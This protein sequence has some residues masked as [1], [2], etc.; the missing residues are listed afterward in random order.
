MT[1]MDE[2]LHLR[3][4]PRAT[5]V[6][7]HDF[8]AYFDAN[9]DRLHAALWLVARDRHEAEEI[10]QDAFL[11]VWERWDRVQRLDDPD[12]YL[13]R[14]AMNLFRNRRRRAGVALRRIVRPPGPRDALQAVEDR[15]AVVRALRSLTPR[16]R[17]A[18][19]LVDLLDMTSEDAA[20]ALGVR[21]ATVRVLAARA[22]ATL[23]ERMKGD[24]DA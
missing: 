18:L 14:T 8:D 20:K 3:I 7:D 13:F 11:K 2:P 5:A 16:Q 9:R 19:V 10:A 24:D 23:R 21:A 1:A 4:S 15:D 17:S 6:A 12:G 22:R